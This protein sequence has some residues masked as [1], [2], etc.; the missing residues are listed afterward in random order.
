MNY[1]LK[2]AVWE[3]TYLCNMRCKHCG[4]GCGIPLEDELS[5]EEALKVC[6]DLGRLGCGHLT[7]SGGEPFMR[8]DWPLL[9]RR[10]KEN[11][12]AVNCISNGWF[13]DQELLDTAKRVG[14]SNIGV[15]LDGLKETHDFIRMK[16]SFERALGALELMRQNGMPTVVCTTVNKKNIKELSRLKDIIYER[17]V[18]RWQFQIG[19]P[20]GNLLKNSELLL[21][22][23]GIEELVNFCH[24][25]M[26]EGR[27][28]IDI[29]DCIGYY[30]KKDIELRK[31][32]QQS[33][34]GVWRGCG[35]GK[36]AVGIRANGDIYGCLSI[37]DD[38]YTEG[39][40]RI[41]SLCEIW[42]KPDAFAWNR[43]MSGDQL[44]C[45]CA[46]CQ[47]GPICLGG[48]SGSKIIINKSITH[49]DQCLFKVMVDK[50]REKA[51]KMNVLK[52]LISATRTFID[53]K[54]YQFADVYLKRALEIEP[55][56]IEV[57]NLL[58][59]VNYSMEKF[60]VSKKYNEMAL[61]QGTSVPDI[62]SSKKSI[63]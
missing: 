40:V 63:A 55:K 1:R 53:R 47:Y 54:E 58:G 27:V 16:G 41:K 6:D 4:S 51:R 21:P 31:M 26:K 48:C 25:T 3:I 11:G 52:E 33:S 32:S 23:E 36:T 13:V 28:V 56:N 45:F 15:S 49:N 29:A 57:I 34:D 18:Q 43:K 12:V 30:S 19:N 10:L 22:R 37:R 50:E 42:S 17:G 2:H 59:Y 44:T 14:I 39:N 8:K 38:K 62:S 20:M 35:A 61:A 24:D 9:T 7:L 46:E 60:D 5:T